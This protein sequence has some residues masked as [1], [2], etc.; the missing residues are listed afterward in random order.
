MTKDI[1][2]LPYNAFNQ[3]DYDRY[4]LDVD[5]ETKQPIK[6][7]LYIKQEDFS[8]KIPSYYRYLYRKRHEVYEL[9]DCVVY[10]KVDTRNPAPCKRTFI[11]RG[12]VFMIRQDAV[13]FREDTPFKFSRN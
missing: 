2:E 6:L 1:S 10:H 7:Y 8:N 4:Y 5:E 3:P 13:P 9:N 11:Q 12:S